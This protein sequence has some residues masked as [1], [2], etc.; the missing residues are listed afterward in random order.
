MVVEET[1]DIEHD[2]ELEYRSDHVEGKLRC[3]HK[4]LPENAT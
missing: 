3:A 1:V 2:N 4:N